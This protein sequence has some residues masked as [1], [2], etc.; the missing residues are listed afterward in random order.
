MVYSLEIYIPKPHSLTHTPKISHKSILLPVNVSNITGCVMNSVD[1]DQTPQYVASDLG[2][3][4][5]R[6]SVFRIRTCSVTMI[7]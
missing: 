3:H 7:I 2:L 6:R 4:C 5:L 1:P